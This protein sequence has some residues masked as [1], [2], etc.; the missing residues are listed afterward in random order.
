MWI[1]TNREIQMRTRQ[2]RL[3]QAGPGHPVGRTPLPFLPMAL[4]THSARRF[5]LASCLPVWILPVH[6]VRLRHLAYLL[7]QTSVQRLSTPNKRARALSSPLLSQQA[8]CFLPSRACL[9]PPQPTRPA[10]STSTLWTPP[11]F[12]RTFHLLSSHHTQW[13]SRMSSIASK[14]K[15]LR[16]P[17]RNAWRVPCSPRGSCHLRPQLPP[18]SQPTVSTCASKKLFWVYQSSA[19]M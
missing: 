15:P 11:M 18:V 7:V 9:P 14:K 1:R 2:H 4:P 17:R 3:G 5:D 19:R 10:R 16:C 13:Y 6:D 12:A 8:F